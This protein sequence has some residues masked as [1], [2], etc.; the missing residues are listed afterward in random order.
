MI[1]SASV[2][3]QLPAELSPRR[4]K[5]MGPGSNALALSH[6]HPIR[7]QGRFAKKKNY[8]NLL[9]AQKVQLSG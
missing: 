1:T 5:K 9:A 4:V 6:K 8:V 2:D 7:A 3:D